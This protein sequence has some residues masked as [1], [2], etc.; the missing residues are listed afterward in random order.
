MFPNFKYNSLKTWERSPKID[1][2]HLTTILGNI[3]QDFLM[4]RRTYYYHSYIFL[5]IQ[6]Y[7]WLDHRRYQIDT[8]NF[9][10]FMF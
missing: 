10:Q 7:I 9:Y 6:L 1:V 5:D 3:L 4:E 2:F 8:E